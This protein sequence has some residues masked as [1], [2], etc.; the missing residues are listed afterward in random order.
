MKFRENS[1]GEGTIF[2]FWISSVFG[3]LGGVV[4]SIFKLS[5]FLVERTKWVFPL[6]NHGLRV[7]SP[8]DLV[9]CLG[10]PHP[11]GVFSRRLSY[12]HPLTYTSSTNSSSVVSRE[13]LGSGDSPPLYIESHP[14]FGICG[15][16]L[17]FFLLSGV[18][19]CFLLC[20]L[21]CYR[22]PEG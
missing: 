22:T 5:F 18:V 7:L 9:L 15:I 17:S 12:H 13:F 4:E 3:F 1:H 21:L 11:L 14:C 8:T 10:V 16:L 20:F 6:M 19:L 2:S